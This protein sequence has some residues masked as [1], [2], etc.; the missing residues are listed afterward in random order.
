[1]GRMTQI[2]Y[3]EPYPN[4]TEVLV[5]WT[6][7]IQAPFYPIKDILDWLETAPGGCFH[8]HGYHSTEG[9]AFRFEDPRDA[10]LFRLKWLL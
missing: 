3:Q 4:W 5:L 2:P 8:L 1:M 9:F 7:I 6:D 10:F